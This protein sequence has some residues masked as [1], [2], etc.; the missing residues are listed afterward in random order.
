MK[1]VVYLIE[2]NGLKY[3]GSITK[4]IKEYR[5]TEHKNRLFKLYNMKTNEYSIKY[6]KKLNTIKKMNLEK[7]NSI[8]NV[9]VMIGLIK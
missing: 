3:V 9:I 1:G 8:T 6:L 5:F 2:S 4:N 7:E